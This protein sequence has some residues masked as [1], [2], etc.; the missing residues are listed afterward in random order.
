MRHI[1]SYASL[2]EASY[3]GGI[4]I[5][6]AWYD[7]RKRAEAVQDRL[8]F[9]SD[10]AEQHL[11]IVDV[12][13]RLPGYSD[14]FRVHAPPRQMALCRFHPEK[15]PSLRL[16]EKSKRFRCHGCGI[17]G[18]LLELIAGFDNCIA[19]WEDF[20]VLP[21]EAQEEELR[22]LERRLVRYGLWLHV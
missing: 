22:V 6:F 1:T 5:D 13:M 10:K 17:E 19:V 2:C 4:M 9:L 16:W 8:E 12:W 3:F 7:M 11:S 18:G 21:I 20:S 15:T 14:T